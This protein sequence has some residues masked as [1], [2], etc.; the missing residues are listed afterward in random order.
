MS[1]ELQALV[2]KIVCMLGVWSSVWHVSFLGL[3]GLRQSLANDFLHSLD[4]LFEYFA[5][6]CIVGCEII[7]GMPFY[8]CRTNLSY[9]QVFLFERPLI[10]S[11]FSSY[12]GNVCAIVLG[13]FLMTH[14]AIFSLNSLEKRDQ[15]LC[16]AVLT[17]A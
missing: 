16:K 1:K 2:L 6:N 11:S 12:F 10:I 17:S 14:L 5:F 13:C 15:L 7:N 9:G 4:A 3:L 8:A